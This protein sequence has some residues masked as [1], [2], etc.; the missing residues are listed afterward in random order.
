M[1]HKLYR[2]VH[3]ESVADYTLKITFDD[4]STQTINF[5][6]VLKGALFGPLQDIAVQM[7]TNHRL[8]LI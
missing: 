4:D 5:C 6:P 2:V 7:A 3:F 8:T 1:S